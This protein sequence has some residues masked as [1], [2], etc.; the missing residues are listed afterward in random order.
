ML[1]GGV[2][3]GRGGGG[4]GGPGLAGVEAEEKEEFKFVG[5]K[6]GAAVRAP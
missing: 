3:E 2:L 1:P 5:G 4:G 6:E